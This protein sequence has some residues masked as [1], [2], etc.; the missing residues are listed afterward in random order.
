MILWSIDQSVRGPFASCASDLCRRWTI[1][2]GEV[3]GTFLTYCT[4]NGVGAT[5]LIPVCNQ[6]ALIHDRWGL[7]AIW[8]V[9]INLS[10]FI[11]L[12]FTILGDIQLPGMPS[13][14]WTLPA[15]VRPH[16]S[17][18]GCKVDGLRQPVP[19]S[20]PQGP[21]TGVPHTAVVCQAA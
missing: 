12:H 3:I 14:P 11:L 18:H 13:S 19:T 10:T 15:S 21:V 7:I 2:V 6:P 20:E 5:I 9:P 4:I 16:G 8:W 17:I 1:L